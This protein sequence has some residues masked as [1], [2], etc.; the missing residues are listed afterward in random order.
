[1][2]EFNLANVKDKAQRHLNNGAFRGFIGCIVSSTIPEE[3][4][5]KLPAGTTRESI[6]GAVSYLVDRIVTEEEFMQKSAVSKIYSAVYISGYLQGIKKSSQTLISEA[7]D[8]KTIEETVLSIQQLMTSKSVANISV[9]L[10]NKLRKD[11]IED[12]V[13]YQKERA[14]EDE[15]VS[16]IDNT[17]GD[18]VNTTSPTSTGLDSSIDNIFKDDEEDLNEPDDTN[19]D[20]DGDG[21]VTPEP[22]EEKTPEEIEEEKK[23]IAEA[24]R[25]ELASRQRPYYTEIFEITK[26][27]CVN[28]K[29]CTPEYSKLLLVGAIGLGNF[30]DQLNIVPMPEYINRLKKALGYVAPTPP[31]TNGMGINVL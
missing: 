10:S 21:E 26:S 13:K 23:L 17:V 11:L 8:T 14:K 15:L 30:L 18:R 20:I 28:D 27:I 16:K 5:R 24:E 12:N 29:E 19:P 31:I 6:A 3:L 2:M 25:V 1:M 9:A 4:V 7:P 22:E